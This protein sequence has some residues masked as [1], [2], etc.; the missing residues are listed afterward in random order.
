MAEPHETIG[1]CVN[2]GK[3]KKRRTEE[4]E[5]AGGQD[6]GVAEKSRC[7]TRRF[8][9]VPRSQSQMAFFFLCFLFLS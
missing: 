8:P 3:K 5:E 7:V 2:G 1:R 9:F 4:E 6:R